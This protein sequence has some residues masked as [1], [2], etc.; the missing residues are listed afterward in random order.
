MNAR[1]EWIEETP[2]SFALGEVLLTLGEAVEKH[3]RNVGVGATAAAP[4]QYADCNIAAP[5]AAG[6]GIVRRLQALLQREV[7]GSGVLQTGFLDAE[8]CAAW[9]D[10]TADK[11]WMRTYPGNF[12]ITN[13]LDTLDGASVDTNGRI[14]HHW[15]CNGPMVTPNCA[16]VPPRGDADPCP[17]GMQRDDT[18]REC[19]PLVECPPGQQ[20]DSAGQCVPIVCGEGEVFDPVSGQCVAA[21]KTSSKKRKSSTGGLLLLASAAVAAIAMATQV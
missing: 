11:P 1:I 5:S 9:R 3:R 6:Q 12:N 17:A 20:R 13:I 21:P 2:S 15:K 4:A 16:Q 7:P 18:T 8:T 14:V 19:V 10:Y